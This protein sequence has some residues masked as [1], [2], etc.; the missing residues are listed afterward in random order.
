MEIFL[1]KM[2]PFLRLRITDNHISP[3]QMHVSS[4]NTYEKSTCCCILK[5]KKAGMSVS[6]KFLYPLT[7]L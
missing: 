3:N 5:T 1:L 2:K 6:Q 7:E 4:Q